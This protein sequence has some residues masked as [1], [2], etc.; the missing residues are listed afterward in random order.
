[1]ATHSSILAWNTSWPEEPGRLQS[2]KLLRVRQKWAHIHTINVTF[3]VCVP[4][5]HQGNC[6][7]RN[8]KKGRRLPL[9][10]NAIIFYFSDI[11]QKSREQLKKLS[12][13]YVLERF[14]NLMEVTL[15]KE[16]LQ[17]LF[18]QE[19]LKVRFTAIS[20]H[21]GQ[22]SVRKV[23]FLGAPR[24]TESQTLELWTEI[25]VLI[26]KLWII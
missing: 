25:H 13:L 19:L 12:W 6:Y 3:I 4:C 17:K 7:R 2:M 15:D 5:T 18:R 9:V 16:H 23:K 8:K 1:M 14:A 24:P 11:L 21:I 26:L 10:D 22:E 20:I